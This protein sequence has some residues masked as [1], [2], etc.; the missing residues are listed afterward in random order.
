MMLYRSKM[1][2]TLQETMKNKM[3]NLQLSPM[4]NTAGFSLT[5]HPCL[6]LWMLSVSWQG[7]QNFW[8]N[9]NLTSLWNSR[10]CIM[11][12]TTPPRSKELP[13]E[14]SSDHLRNISHQQILHLGIPTPTTTESWRQGPGIKALQQLKISSK[15]PHHHW[16]LIEITDW[17]PWLWDSTT[18]RR[19]I[20]WTRNL[21]TS[22]P[23]I[24]PRTLPLGTWETL[25]TQQRLL[26]VIE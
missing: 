5:L 18:L 12:I 2:K 22:S 19:Y 21:Q 26:R 15:L 20:L 16:C 1:K 6:K 10:I 9:S 24:F 13:G 14:P 17:Q 4:N 23:F 3:Q 25:P 8:D 7:F 11:M